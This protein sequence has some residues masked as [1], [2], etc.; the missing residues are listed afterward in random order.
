MVLG[1]GEEK[2]ELQSAIVDDGGVIGVARGSVQFAHSDVW[3]LYIYA[4]KS[5]ITREKYQ[6]RFGKFLNCIAEL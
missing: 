4:M 1:Q 3:T 6:I 5:L 2:K